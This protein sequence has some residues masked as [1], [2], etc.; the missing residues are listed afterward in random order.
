MLGGALY[1]K[2][3]FLIT[4]WYLMIIFI[5]DAPGRKVIIAAAVVGRAEKHMARHDRRTP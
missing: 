2:L 5:F 3:Y 1:T 4:L